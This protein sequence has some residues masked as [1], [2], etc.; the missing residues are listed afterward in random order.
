MTGLSECGYRDL[1][2]DDGL[3]QLF[4]LGADVGTKLRAVALVPHIIHGAILE[5]QFLDAPALELA[6]GHIEVESEPGLG[7]TMRVKLPA[8]RGAAAA[9]AAGDRGTTTPVLGE[10]G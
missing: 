4:R 6:R 1:A 5:A 10:G 9:V 2:S 3:A 7:T 8:R